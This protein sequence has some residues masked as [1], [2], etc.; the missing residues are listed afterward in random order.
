MNDDQNACLLHECTLKNQNTN[1]ERRQTYSQQQMH[2]FVF[3]G[4]ASSYFEDVSERTSVTLF[5]VSVSRKRDLG[6]HPRPT[7]GGMM[8]D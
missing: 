4:L 5:R 7:F 8:V 1:G 6:R 3:H 2:N